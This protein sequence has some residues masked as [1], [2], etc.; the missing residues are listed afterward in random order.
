MAL[1]VTLTARAPAQPTQ[2]HVTIHRVYVTCRCKSRGQSSASRRRHVAIFHP[3]FSSSLAFS[4]PPR[5]PPS[6]CPPSPNIPSHS[7][8]P[9]PTHPTSLR[10]HSLVRNHAFV[11]QQRFFIRPRRLQS[12]AAPHPFI[13]CVVSKY[14]ASNKIIF[15][16]S[17]LAPTRIASSSISSPSLTTDS[18]P[19][20]LTTVCISPR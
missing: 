15:Y 6:P 2:R 17:T 11:L 5:L 7:V 20:H 9:R 19:Q 18:I 16:P 12:S 10:A 3:H 13:P 4:S 14:S 1:T 8:V